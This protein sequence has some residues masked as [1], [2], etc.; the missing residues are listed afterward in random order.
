M[1]TRYGYLIAILVV[2]AIAIFAATRRGWRTGLFAF[3]LQLVLA[4]LF[5]QGAW[6]L[7]QGNAVTAALAALLSPLCV[8]LI[9]ITLGRVNTSQR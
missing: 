8:L 6:L 1:E 2:V 7:S 3:I 4:G 9:I 5:Y